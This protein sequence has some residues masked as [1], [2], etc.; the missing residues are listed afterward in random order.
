MLSKRVSNTRTLLLAAVL[1]VPHL[2]VQV[3]AQRNITIPTPTSEAGPSNS[4]IANVTV[5]G[6]II[7][8]NI[9]ATASGN[10]TSSNATRTTSSTPDPTK[11]FA[12]DFQTQTYRVPAPAAA[13]GGD[14]AQSPDDSVSML[15]IA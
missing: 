14:V 11:P 8:G 4:S 6:S 10:S 12:T 7:S 3:H 9:T 1:L 5:S 13:G 15:S 2:F